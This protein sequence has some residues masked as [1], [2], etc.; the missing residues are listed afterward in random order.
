MAESQQRGVD[1]TSCGNTFSS[2]YK[3]LCAFT[4]AV[5][6]VVIDELYARSPVHRYYVDFYI[7]T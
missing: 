1:E 7:F 2:G 4:I 3:S 6:L 5:L